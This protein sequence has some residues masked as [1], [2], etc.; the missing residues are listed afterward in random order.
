VP[1]A[2]GEIADERVDFDILVV[3]AIDQRRIQ[4]AISVQDHFKTSENITISS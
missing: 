1:E 2:I 3:L 4:R